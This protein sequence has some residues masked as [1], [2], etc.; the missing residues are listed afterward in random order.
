MDN[1]LQNH[2]A[3]IELKNEMGHIWRELAELKDA[4]NEQT[5]ELKAERKDH[6]QRIRLLE[7]QQKMLDSRWKAVGKTIA[8]IGS[9]LGI[10]G[11]IIGI[12]VAFF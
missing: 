1:N 7:I 2:D 3:V 9:L 8:I 12:A 11:A 6:S 5:V 4:V 10:A